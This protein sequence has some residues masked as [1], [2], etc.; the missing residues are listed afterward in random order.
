MGAQFRHRQ[1]LPARPE[2]GNGTLISY[3]EEG[4]SNPQQALYVVNNTFANDNARHAVTFIHAAGTPTARIVNDL[5]LGGGA[6][7][8][9]AGAFQS[10]DLAATPAD[11][12][13]AAAGDYHLA[14]RSKAI[15]AGTAPGAVGGFDLTPQFEYARPDTLVPRP[16]HSSLDVGAYE[17]EGPLQ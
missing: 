6:W 5:F 9:W 14:P 16:V 13:N 4:A 10:H 3:A 15:N 11:F 7:T 2:A 1:R 17:G 12:V 8:S